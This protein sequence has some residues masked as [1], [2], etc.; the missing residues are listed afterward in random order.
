MAV[1]LNP[2]SAEANSN[3]ANILRY[4]KRFD[5]AIAY[6]KKASDL[7]PDIASIQGSLA[8]ALL[9][10]GKVEE[11]VPRYETALRLDASNGLL[12]NNLAWTLA[13][14]PKA[15]VRN[16]AR[17]VELALRAVQI[18]GSQDPTVM[19]TLAAAYAEAGRFKEAIEIE[20]KAYS[21]SKSMEDAEATEWHSQLLESY[22]AG[23]PY[24][25]NSIVPK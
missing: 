18:I 24:R 13:T 4:Q 12:M 20:E 22:R 25:E 5:E 3:L 8:N 14:C 10:V 1:K 15:S 9:D 19:G 17:A 6:Y 23:E 2:D 21:L 7:R 11:A 16:G